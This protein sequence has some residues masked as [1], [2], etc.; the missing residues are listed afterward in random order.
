MTSRTDAPQAAGTPNAGAAL[1]VGSRVMVFIDGQNLFKGV[2]RRFK[3]R[4]H[5][6][7][8]ADALAGPERQLA[9]TFYYSGI[10]DPDVDR[11]MFDLVRRRHDLI[12]R[13]GVEVHERTLRYHWEWSVDYDDVPPPWYDDA[14]KKATATVY[15]K[16]KA[17][18]KGIDV[19]LALDAVSAILGDRCDV[20]VIVSRDRDLMEVADQVRQ[21][22]WGKSVQ[23]EVSYVS[24][25]RGDE[26]P[27]SG[28]LSA[29]DAFREVTESIVESARDDFNYSRPLDAATVDRFLADLT[30]G[31]NASGRDG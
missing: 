30:V 29:Y 26:R 14:P 25:R 31:A 27:L 9:G 15:K 11:K 3:T 17:R 2:H 13:T 23:V 12:Q 20:A 4:V 8:L 5:P 22:C 28:A 24:E 21:K 16:R 6:I 10:H 7:L 1:N 19:A 18:E